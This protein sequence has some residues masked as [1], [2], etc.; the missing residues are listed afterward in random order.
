[1]VICCCLVAAS[2]AGAADSTL[3]QFEIQ[4]QF[5]FEHHDEDFRGSVLLVMVGNKK[6]GKFARA[7]SE[8][9]QDSI[10]AW[11]MTDDVEL[12]SVADVG[13]VPFFL[14]GLVRGKMSKKPENWLLMDW[15][16]KF[17]KA[18]DCEKDVCNLL[19][20]DEESRFVKRT[21]V[22]ELDDAGLQEIQA[23]LA[24]LVG[25]VAPDD[26]GAGESAPTPVNLDDGSEE[27]SPVGDGSR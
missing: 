17:H 8:H 5:K 13:G 21:T 14:K 16:S 11:G 7:W 12:L 26:V 25:L 4:D 9:I 18:Y 2:A 20:F 6:G 19:Y 27:E 15:G 23:E 1:M 22:T 24:G 10:P 3:I